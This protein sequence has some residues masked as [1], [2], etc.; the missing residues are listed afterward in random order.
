MYSL[1]PYIIYKAT[2]TRIV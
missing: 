1:E 2:H